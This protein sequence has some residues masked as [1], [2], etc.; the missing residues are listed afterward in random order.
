MEKEEHPLLPVTKPA[1]KIRSAQCFAFMLDNANI[2]VAKAH[3]TPDARIVALST[4]EEVLR[5]LFP[6]TS[7]WS[8]SVTNIA[9]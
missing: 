7:D 8:P 1:M 3:V 5:S 2:V 9:R 4:G 6:T